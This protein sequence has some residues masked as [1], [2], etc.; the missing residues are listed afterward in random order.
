MPWYKDVKL[1]DP[2]KQTFFVLPSA[3]SLLFKLVVEKKRLLRKKFGWWVKILE[4][5]GSP[6]L[7]RFACKFPI[8]NGCPKS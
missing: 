2:F 4:E 6:L 3:K 8:S 5:L 7:N 1:G